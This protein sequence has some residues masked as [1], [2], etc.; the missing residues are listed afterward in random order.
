MTI[1]PT[2][3]TIQLGMNARL[4]K[5][6]FEKPSC[7]SERMLR[8]GLSISLRKLCPLSWSDK[9]F[10]KSGQ[11]PPI[12]SNQLSYIGGNCA[13]FFIDNVLDERSPSLASVEH[14]LFCQYLPLESYCRLL[15]VV[16]RLQVWGILSKFG[17]ATK[18]YYST[19]EV[20]QQ[21]R[22]P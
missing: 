12:C 5:R 21:F 6:V 2:E 4:V 20:F 17:E 7:H 3:S 18:P 1:S 9:N 16:S 15:T 22:C 19:A 14:S 13:E 8:N 11:R 10:L